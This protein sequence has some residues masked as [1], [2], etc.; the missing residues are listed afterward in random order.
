MAEQEPHPLFL[1]HLQLM[2]AAA[3][4]LDLLPPELLELVALVA[5]EMEQEMGAVTLRPVQPTQAVEAALHT[6]VAIHPAQA[7]PVL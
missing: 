4:V 2:L 6:M 3:A 5:A 7:A 1:A